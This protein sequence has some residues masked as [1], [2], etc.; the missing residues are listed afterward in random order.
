MAWRGEGGARLGEGMDSREGGEVNPG[1]PRRVPT[2]AEQG[3]SVLRWRREHHG[4]AAGERAGW[5]RWRWRWRQASGGRAGGRGG[6]ASPARR[7]RNRARIGRSGFCG[8]SRVR[9][10]EGSYE[11]GR[12]AGAVGGRTGGG[13]GGRSVAGAPDFLMDFCGLDPSLDIRM[14]ESNSDMLLHL[15]ALRGVTRRYVT[16][17]KRYVTR[18]RRYAMAARFG[19]R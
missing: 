15:H 4:M 5:R 11:R 19:A 9:T 3:R 8:R 2:V 6:I 1:R 10:A 18:Y 17:Y 16:R 7:G 13:V 12:T 14:M